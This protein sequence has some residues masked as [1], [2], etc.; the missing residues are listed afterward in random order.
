[1]DV[2]STNL[3]SY[4]DVTD[5]L[6]PWH[7]ARVQEIEQR[8]AM[9]DDTLL[10]DIMLTLGG[11]RE[12]DTLYPPID[13]PGLHRLLNGISESTYDAL[14][15][16]CLV[17]FL[18]KWY[19]DGRERKFQ[20]DRL[21]PPQFAQLAEAYW[22]LD[23][24]VNVPMAV[25]LLSDSRLNQDYSSKILQAISTAA[26]IDPHPLI[27][28]YIRT[29][30]PLLTEL[31]DLSLYLV[32]LA[33]HSLFEAW[34]LQRS[35]TDL[36]LA[37]SKLLKKMLEWCV[38]PNLKT[39]ALTHLL[40]MPLTPFEESVLHSYAS[41]PSMTVDSTESPSS[42]GLAAL[43]NLA[44]TRLIQ[45]GQYAD[46]IKLHRRFFSTAA[47]NFTLSSAATKMV[48]QRKD[49]IEGLYSTLPSVERALLDAELRGTPM[50]KVAT[51]TINVNNDDTDMSDSQT[52]EEI[53]AQDLSSRDVHMNGV[54][55]TTS[56][57]VPRASGSTLSIPSTFSTAV[58]TLKDAH[59]SSNSVAKVPSSFSLT[60]SAGPGNRESLASSR[61]GVPRFGGAPPILPISNGGGDSSITL[62]S[63][64]GFGG[65]PSLS[66]SSTTHNL[67]SGIN[68]PSGRKSLPFGSSN[69]DSLGGALGSA[70]F[71]SSKR[72]PNAS[73]TPP[74]INNSP[75]TNPF[76]VEDPKPELGG[77]YRRS[78]TG[79][80]SPE[81]P[82]SQN[83]KQIRTGDKQQQNPEARTMEVDDDGGG[84]DYP[85]FG[86]VEGSIPV[87]DN[88]KANDSAYNDNLRTSQKRPPGAF[89]DD[90]DEDMIEDVI[91]Q[92]PPP[93]QTR[94][95]KSMATAS[96]DA[97]ANTSASAKSSTSI[98]AASGS[99]SAQT[100]KSRGN[101]KPRQ[102]ISTTMASSKSKRRVPGGMFDEDDEDEDDRDAL[103]KEIEEDQDQVA[104]LTSATATRRTTRKTRSS[105]ASALSNEESGP[106]RRSS[107]I[108]MS[109]EGGSG[110]ASSKRV[111]RKSTA[112]TSGKKKQR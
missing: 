71:S 59:I 75:L 112:N 100:S 56:P 41:F 67:N 98:S 86:S 63:S 30:K 49:M 16:D 8:R 42:L 4:F 102:T 25:S 79:S 94:S 97:I 26:D 69:L 36:N 55:S 80:H 48:Q 13:V 24:A 12:S 17:Y 43:Q 105:V 93:P 45:T 37:R 2:D 66:S 46:A 58:P 107:R 74:V 34:Q 91:S 20:R 39:T 96:S 40:A 89:T 87:R 104:S 50:F 108:S 103:D 61:S 54:I 68:Q 5:D 65:I 44:C 77:P 76:S 7:N 99:T 83:E 78:T 84:L 85:L 72:K 90:E 95:R 31:D 88:S 23:A 22:C 9:L 28:R 29:A 14:K 62:S 10:Y 111:T 47:S 109:G 15:K 32:A 1:M 18:L 64:L 92:P 101:K 3:I 82:P 6:F 21:I 35:F 33:H 110:G 106:R 27:V 52:W 38:S 11:I 19:G 60:S 57:D 81:R 73:Y 70:L 51:T 53:R